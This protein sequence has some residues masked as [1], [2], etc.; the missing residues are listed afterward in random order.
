VFGTL[1]VLGDLFS[2]GMAYISS[3]KV[4]DTLVMASVG[5]VSVNLKQ[6]RICYTQASYHIV[7]RGLVAELF[8]DA[9]NYDEQHV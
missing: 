4:I 6:R 8:A 9:L 5:V 7:L 2:I 1:D 3:H